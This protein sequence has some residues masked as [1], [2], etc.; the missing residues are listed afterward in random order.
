MAKHV[1]DSL[2]NHEKQLK[3]GWFSQIETVND[4]NQDQIGK[5]LERL[6][7]P[8][9]QHVSR[10]CTPVMNSYNK[11]VARYKLRTQK[12]LCGGGNE[13]SLHDKEE[14]SELFDFYF[15]DRVSKLCF[16][17]DIDLICD[18]LLY[19]TTE[20]G[21]LKGLAE[22]GSY[23]GEV[24]NFICDYLSKQ[25]SAKGIMLKNYSSKHFASLLDEI[26]VHPGE[27]ETDWLYIG[28]D[29]IVAVEIGLSDPEAKSNY[30]FYQ[31]VKNKLI[32]VLE[33][34]IPHLQSIIYNLTKSLDDE[35]KD[36]V[37]EII[38]K[39]LQ[40]VVV[41]P[42]ITAAQFQEAL[43]NLK[44]ELHN[45]QSKLSKLLKYNEK[46]WSQGLFFAPQFG[47]YFFSIDKN[48]NPY[49][50]SQT[51]TDSSTSDV[52]SHLFSELSPERISD[53]GSSKTENESQLFR[54][55]SALIVLSSLN[56]MK[57]WPDE[58]EDRDVDKRYQKSFSIWKSK[59]DNLTYNGNDFILS[60]EQHRILANDKLTRLLIS[61]EPG[62][63]KTSLLLA[64]CR[65]LAE[66]NEVQVIFFVVRKTKKQFLE[67]LRTMIK[68]H[69][70]ETLRRKLVILPVDGDYHTSIRHYLS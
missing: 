55:I 21:K 30:S 58:K 54:D 20:D 66:H 45:T 48:L 25:P 60:P 16:V 52:Y 17:P 53:F 43:E 39:R 33:R 13:I 11:E 29:T 35:N 67:F 23:I 40:V 6:A 47:S 10:P 12:I 18:N 49:L 37:I 38:T 19:K 44:E 41:L 68:D 22:T 3:T 42:N 24:T 28:K 5:V 70:S 34:T 63:G 14:I 65:L 15:K 8:R 2:Q 50:I 4:K 62:S 27:F 32:Q 69:G 57:F 31:T 7:I 1:H 26:S 51:G 61:G 46:F 9:Y 59:Q 36:N 56:F 64:K